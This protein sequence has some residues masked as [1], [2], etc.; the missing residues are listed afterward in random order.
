V[1]VGIIGEYVQ[2]FVS[3]LPRV[4]LLLALR[5]VWPGVAITVGIG[6]EILFS[7]MVS[8]VEGKIETLANQETARALEQA[9][10]ANLLAEEEGKARAALEKQVEQLRKENNDTALLLSYRSVGD[11]PAFED[12]MRAFNGTKYAMEFLH[13]SNEATNFQWVL[14]IALKNAGWIPVRLPWHRMN[15]G[16]GVWVMT[17]GDGP[18]FSRSEAA[19][20][21]A[22]WLDASQIATI[23]AVVKRDDVAGTVIIQVGPRPETIEQYDQMRSEYRRRRE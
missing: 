1:L 15:L 9:A 5:A 17:V 7:M 10:K 6:G 21:L 19:E 12:A 18:P 14:N 22:D 4:G 11:M 3:A 2:P 8:S 20:A 16:F 23:T 13:P